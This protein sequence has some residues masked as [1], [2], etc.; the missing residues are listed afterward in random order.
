MKTTI[1]QRPILFSTPMVQ[2]ILQSR[3]LMTR[4]TRSLDQVN[5]DPNS[6]YFDR[7]GFKDE[8]LIAIFK[9]IGGDF[10]NAIPCPYGK[11]GDQIWVRETWAETCDEYGTPVM[12]Y[13]VG[14]PRVILKDDDGYKL[15]GKITTQWSIDSYPSY[16]KWKPSI[17][18][19]HWASRLHLEI[20]DIRVER[21]QS[22]TEA[23]AIA[24]GVQR[25]AGSNTLYR[26][27]NPVVKSLALIRG[28]QAS[29]FTLW[30]SLN[31]KDSVEANPWLWVIK[32]K[33]VEG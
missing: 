21:L 14:Q 2:G 25:M 6:W 8:K 9:P 32:F 11:P 27:Y 28:A 4:R 29:F 10:G 7:F 18:M 31:G 5:K 15:G 16:G 26:H 3:K 13:K 23:D 30:E 19:S 20:T 33:V 1:K 17:H 22:I 12:A 24:E